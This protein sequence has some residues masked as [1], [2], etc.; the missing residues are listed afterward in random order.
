MTFKL[1]LVLFCLLFTSLILMFEDILYYKVT[2]LIACINLFITMVVA[3]TTDYTPLFLMSGISL[4]FLLTTLKIELK[5]NLIDYIYFILV[6]ME[7]LY[8]RSSDIY[9]IQFLLVSTLPLDLL[10]ISVC[11]VLKRSFKI[12]YLFVIL[13]L[14]TIY[15]ITIYHFTLM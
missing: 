12:P 10:A 5:F 4:I 14:H 9:D 11:L 15:L 6:I 1:V 2:S 3:S 13:P 7:I 8:L